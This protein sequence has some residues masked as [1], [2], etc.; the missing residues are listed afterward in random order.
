MLPLTLLI[1]QYVGL[2]L[3]KRI[4]SFIVVKG[5]TLVRIYTIFS[6]DKP[7]NANLNSPVSMPKLILRMNHACNLPTLI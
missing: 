5:L 2:S 3:N 4:F 1:E 7:S 6:H